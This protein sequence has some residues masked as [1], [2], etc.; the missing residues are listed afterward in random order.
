[1]D[2]K[3][4]EKIL[5]AHQAMK[6]EGRDSNQFEFPWSATALGSDDRALYVFERSDRPGAVQVRFQANAEEVAARECPRRPKLGVP[7]S[8]LRDDRG[9]LSKRA[10]AR[11]VE[12]AKREF[13]KWLTLPVSNGSLPERFETYEEVFRYYLDPG[14]CPDLSEGHR[15]RNIGSFD[16]APTART[17][18]AEWRR[19]VGM[20][21]KVAGFGYELMRRV[22]NEL[23]AEYEDG[24]GATKAA[25]LFKTVIAAI[26]H[27]K[28]NGK[29]PST[30][31]M[32]PPKWEQTLRE[33]WTKRHKVSVM[34][35]K[36]LRYTEPEAI[37]LLQ[38]LHLA[39]PRLALAIELTLGFRLIQVAEQA[40]RRSLREGGPY[41]L[42]LVVLD[43]KSSRP[44]VID[45]SP[46]QQRA[47]RAAWGPGGLLHALEEAYKA[48]RLENYFLI[49]GGRTRAG[50]AP[51][52]G[53]GRA[54]S[55]RGLFENL[56]AL[57]KVA[58][59]EYKPG[60]S[61][62]GLRRTITRLVGKQTDDATL[63]DLAQGWTPGSGARKLYDAAE[64]DED[65]LALAAEARVKA[66]ETISRAL[67][68]SEQVEGLAS[69]ATQLA[70][71]IADTSD[72]DDRA[73]GALAEAADLVIR[74]VNCLE[75]AAEELRTLP[76]RER[77]S[78][79]PR[80][81]H[82][83][84]AAEIRT[85]I[86]RRSLSGKRASELLGVSDSDISAIRRGKSFGL[87]RL[88]RLVRLRNTLANLPE[89]EA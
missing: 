46:R 82:E 75:G 22:T 34:K 31:A 83:A 89:E 79:S 70:T 23:V 76:A 12:A 62:H 77:A 42:Q 68:P 60:R 71:R 69:A 74:L 78:Q 19:R 2:A 41:G 37:L 29:L 35:P 50:V 64:E 25:R 11:A 16:D 8:G 40:T 28:A 51:L 88:E 5:A 85:E 81:Q 67:T 45:L 53:A 47:L 26:N 36:R 55:P 80:E 52:S 18:V 63:R 33:T 13:E 27:A 14:S 10:G 56:R 39:R 73:V 7:V 15:K 84:V 65:Q 20:K 4:T 1:M 32:A 48:G 30:V 9:R 59:V 43:G 24:K 21:E 61:F 86:K 57:E 54:T 38:H 72:S 6:D 3:L 87:I 58:G 49:P 17:A 44:I 66:I